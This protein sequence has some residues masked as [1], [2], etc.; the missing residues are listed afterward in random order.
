MTEGSRLGLDQTYPGQG[1]EL[2]ATSS[3]TPATTLEML[4]GSLWSR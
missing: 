1:R 2:S 3:S 4:A